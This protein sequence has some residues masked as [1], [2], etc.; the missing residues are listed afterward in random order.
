MIRILVI[1]DSHGDSSILNL[2]YLTYQ[3]FDYYLDLGDSCLPHYMIE[4][5]TSVKG[6]NDYGLEY[7]P[8]RIIHT[9]YGNIYLEHGDHYIDDEYI[10]SKDC[11]LFLSGHTHRRSLR[12]LDST[13]YALNPGS[14]AYPRDNKYGTYLIISLDENGPKFEF[15]EWKGDL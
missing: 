11:L 13:H 6:N 15:K 7:P 8:S 5:F 9:K 2:L 12:K 3:N 10:L 4:P 14:I 1:S